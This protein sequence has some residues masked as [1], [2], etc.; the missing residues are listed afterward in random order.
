[1]NEEATAF[2]ILAPVA[3][4]PRKRRATSKYAAIW[5]AVD[6]LQDGAWLPVKCET[7]KELRLIQ[8]SAGSN[9]NNTCET[10]ADGLTL[11]LR[12]K[13]NG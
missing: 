8:T 6:K 3:T 11:Y 7:A 2:E 13:R 1:M 9:R 10:F 12:R 5:E 4:L